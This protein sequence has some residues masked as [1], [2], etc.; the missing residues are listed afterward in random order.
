VEIE[1]PTSTLT[2]LDERITNL[3]NA[4]IDLFVNK[5]ICVFGD[6]ITWL[7]LSG[8]P[9][10]GWFTH[11]KELLP[12]KEAIN[13]A[14]SGATW[15]NTA[16]TVYNITEDEG[17][18]S[19][20]NVVYNQINR[21]LK[22]IE[23]GADAPDYIMILAGTNDQWYP[24]ARPD[25]VSKEA[26]E[27]FEDNTNYLT[28]KQPSECTSIAEAIRYVAEMLFTNLPDTQ[29]ILC[30]PL[31]GTHGNITYNSEVANIIK[32]C[33]AYM[34]WNVIE[35]NKEC[36][37]SRLQE[38]RGFYNTYDGVHTSEVGAKMVAGILAS[39]CKS[40]LKISK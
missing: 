23:D 39:K 17:G 27:V 20:N 15:S 5:K 30:T 19:D 18:M 34:G 12:F 22:D 29:V 7:A 26:K 31:Q 6:S 24:S 25:A 9:Q 35:Q 16:N 10:R 1:E 4:Q 8:N 2:S 3:E 40:I 13:Y 21:L 33:G 11:F 38:T 14:R 37:I 28:S 36:G 32:D